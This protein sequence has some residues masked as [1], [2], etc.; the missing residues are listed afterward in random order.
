M[1]YTINSRKFQKAVT[2][3]RPGARYVYV[4]VT[5]GSRPGTLGEQM[6]RGGRLSS[7]STVE[8]VGDQAGFEQ[9]CR[10]WWKQYLKD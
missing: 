1:T 3:S 10:N 4:D 8:Y 2:F 6:C 7:G 5:G 9:L